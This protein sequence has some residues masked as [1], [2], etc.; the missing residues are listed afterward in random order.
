[1]ATT[2]SMMPSGN[3]VGRLTSSCNG[4]NENVLSMIVSTHEEMNPKRRTTSEFAVYTVISCHF[5][6]PKKVLMMQI[7]KNV[8]WDAVEDCHVVHAP[9]TWGALDPGLAFLGVYDGHGGR[10]MVEYL[11]HFLSFHVAEELKHDDDDAT[12]AVRLERAFV[13]ADIHAMQCGVN[14]SGATVVTCLVQVC[15]WLF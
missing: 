14:T 12:M 7:K 13:L 9:G 4:G 8:L 5:I 2:E 3:A 6:F 10:D 1:M 11:E 15:P